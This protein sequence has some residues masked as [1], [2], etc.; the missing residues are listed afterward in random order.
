MAMHCFLERYYQATHADE[1]GALLGG[2]SL[3]PDGSPADPG[4]RREWLD[5]IEAVMGGEAGGR[6]QGADLRFK[7]EPS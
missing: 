5:A 7:D 3:L 4:F 1:V 2:L 6:Y